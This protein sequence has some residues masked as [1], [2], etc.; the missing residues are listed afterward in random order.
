MNYNYECLPCGEHC[1]TC[2]HEIRGCRACE[3]GYML[4]IDNECI[5]IESDK[6]WRT[7]M[8]VGIGLG[9]LVFIATI[10]AIWWMWRKPSTELVKVGKSAYEAIIH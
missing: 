9:I 7:I 2:F 8:W 3:D 5:K 4:E 10:I 1:L 6:D